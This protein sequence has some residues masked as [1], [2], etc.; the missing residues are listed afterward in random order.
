VERESEL[1][2]GRSGR[3]RWSS[4][5]ASQ[6]SS[7]TLTFVDMVDQAAADCSPLE[8]PFIPG[9]AVRSRFPAETTYPRG[10]GTPS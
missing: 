3:S 5:D 9:V 4:A 7:A 6:T 2:A 8:I 1:D 10:T